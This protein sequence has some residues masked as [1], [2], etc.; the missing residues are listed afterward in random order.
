[1]C[2]IPLVE[3]EAR[4]RNLPGWKIEANELVK[5]FA[6]RDFRASLRFVNALGEL[7]EEA[8]HHPDIDVRYNKVRL[9]LT[10]HD[11][12]GLTEKDFS[13]ASQADGIA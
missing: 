8:G 1:M 10:T 13:L 11:D 2:P 4:L 5:T 3:A 7:A 9:A 6:F 12:G